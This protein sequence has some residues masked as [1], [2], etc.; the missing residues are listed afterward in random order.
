MLRLTIASTIALGWV[1]CHAPYSAA[2]YAQVEEGAMTATICHND[3]RTLTI[4]ADDWAEHR[5]HGDYRG[6][7]RERR[8]VGEPARKPVAQ[9]ATAYEGNRDR[10]K[11]SRASYEAKEALKEARLDSLRKADQE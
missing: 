5:A 1:S 7:C 11:A 8:V 10:L 3:K 6:P 4:A 2:S 9:T